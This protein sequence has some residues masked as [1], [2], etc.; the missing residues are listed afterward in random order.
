MFL[1][2]RIR[3]VDSCQLPLTGAMPVR[4]PHNLF[5]VSFPP[6]LHSYGKDE[7]L[8]VPSP[9][10]WEYINIFLIFSDVFHACSKAEDRYNLIRKL[11]LIW[12]I[13]NIIIFK[14]L[15]P[16]AWQ[17]I[18]FTNSKTNYPLFC[19]FGEDSIF[20]P[21]LWTEPGHCTCGANVLRG[22]YDLRSHF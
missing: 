1:A 15:Q 12:T 14:P 17:S 19:V 10:L 11:K 22:S 5:S 21:V 20:H 6:S 3:P 13:F 2:F 16:M 9:T 4:S 7:V 18:A 8:S